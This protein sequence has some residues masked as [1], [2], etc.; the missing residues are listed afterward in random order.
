MS[1]RLARTFY[2]SRNR[3]KLS[4]VTLTLTFHGSPK[5][6][7]Q[8]ANDTLQ[9]EKCFHKCFHEAEAPYLLNQAEYKADIPSQPTCF[10]RVIHAWHIH[11]S[12]NFA[13]NCSDSRDVFVGM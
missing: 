8:N 10:D 1:C 3:D 13:W 6:V 7:F 9:L 2:A 4:N 11:E 5:L 12:H